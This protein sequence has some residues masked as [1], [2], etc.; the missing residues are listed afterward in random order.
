MNKKQVLNY[1]LQLTDG[2]EVTTV[3]TLSMEVGINVNISENTLR[4][5]ELSKWATA[6]HNAEIN[7]AIKCLEEV[8]VIC[9]NSLSDFDLQKLLRL[10]KFLQEAGRFIESKDKFQQLIDIAD[11]YNYFV[12][13]S[14]DLTEFYFAA[15]KNNFLAE[16]YDAMR[17]VYK[18]EKQIDIS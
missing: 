5:R 10:P 14:H 2:K 9:F 15:S 16:I 8:W 7:K 11:T 18:R 3:A 1:D 13:D 6:Y 12:C 4:I 17:I